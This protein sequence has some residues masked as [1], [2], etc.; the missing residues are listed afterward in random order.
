VALFAADA[1]HLAVRGDQTAFL[2]YGRECRPHTARVTNAHGDVIAMVAL[3]D[4]FEDLVGTV[5]DGTH[6]V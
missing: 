1:H 4:L 6:R 2:A 5:H 3:E